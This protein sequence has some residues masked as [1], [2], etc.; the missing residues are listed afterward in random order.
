MKIKLYYPHTGKGRHKNNT[1]LSRNQVVYLIFKNHLEQQI[2]KQE[3]QQKRV[4]TTTNKT[5]AETRA[6]KP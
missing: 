2:S 6:T 5:R 3:E 4:L 1:Q